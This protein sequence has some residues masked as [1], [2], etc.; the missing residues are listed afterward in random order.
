L[1]FAA[2][3]SVELGARQVDGRVRVGEMLGHLTDL[4][5]R[6]AHGTCCQFRPYADSW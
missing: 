6:Y 2:T 3:H 1:K 4:D 5:S